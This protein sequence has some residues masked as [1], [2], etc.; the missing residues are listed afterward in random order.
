MTLNDWLYLL[1]GAF[2]PRQFSKAAIASQAGIKLSEEEISELRTRLDDAGY[3]VE[4][5]AHRDGQPF[6]KAEQ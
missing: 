6:L 1:K 4:E 5:I 3:S 2:A